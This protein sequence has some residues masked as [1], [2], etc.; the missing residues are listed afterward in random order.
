MHS[1]DQT[2]VCDQTLPNFEPSTVILPP[3]AQILLANSQGKFP[4]C[5][6]PLILAKANCFSKQYFCSG[7]H[8]DT[9]DA[10]VLIYLTFFKF[11]VL[12]A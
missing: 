1:Y 7:I 4:D 2:S 11:H 10:I 6:L 3:L 8:T 5:S 9:V 12:E